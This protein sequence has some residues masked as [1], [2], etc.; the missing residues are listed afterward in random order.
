[1]EINGGI[2]LERKVKHSSKK[3]FDGSS[4]SK[5]YGKGYFMD[6]EGSNYGRKDE[7]G[8]LLF[9]PYDAE[10]YLY[11]DRLVVD[12]LLKSV[13]NIETAIVLGCARGYMVQAFHERNVEAVG[14]DI[15]EWAVENCAPM[16]ADHIYC[17]DVCDLSKWRD[18][19]FD[20]G[21]A[22]DVFEHIKVPDLYRAL[23]EAA[24]VGKMIVLD[25]P[26]AP[27]DSHPDQS[28]GTDK[29]HVSVYSKEFWVRQFMERGFE[30]DFSQE[31]QYPEAHEDSPWPDKHDHGAT[32]YFT[33]AKPKPGAPDFKSITIKPD[34]KNFKILWWS[35]S[36]FALTGYGIGTKGVV[37]PL[38][39]IYDVRCLSVYGLEGA[40]LYF[41]NLIIYPRLFDQFG[42]DAAQLIVKNW[43]PDVM[44]TLFDLWI[45]DSPLLEGQRDWF[46]KIHPKHIAYFPVDHEP[47]P[48]GVVNQAKQAYRAVTMSQFGQRAMEKAGVRNTMI[49]HGCLIYSTIVLTPEGPQELGQIVESK[50]KVKILAYDGNQYLFTDIQE[51]YKTSIKDGKIVRLV[52]GD[53]WLSGTQDHPILTDKGWVPLG[54]LRKGFNIACVYPRGDIY[55][56]GICSGNNRRRRNNLSFESNSKSKSEIS[57][58][59]NSLSTLL[60]D[61][62]LRRATDERTTPET[63]FRTS[64]FSQGR[65]Y[66]EPVH[67]RLSQRVQSKTNLGGY[68]A[69]PNCEEETS[70]TNASIH[71]QSYIEN[72]RKTLQG[73]I[74]SKGNRL[75]ESD[76]IIF[77][78]ASEVEVR[79]VASHERWVYDI[80][81]EYGNFIA[82]GIIV[83]NCD[84]NTFKPPEDKGKCRKWLYDHSLPLFANKEKEWPEK[85]F[86]L[87]A[88][89]MNKDQIKRKGWDKEFEAIRLF[90]D[91]N[92]DARKDFR[93]HLHT[94][95]QY[96]GGYPL[97][98]LVDK[99][100]FSDIT[101]KTHTYHMYQGLNTE[102]LATMYGGFDVLMNASRGEGFGIPIIEAASCGVPAI[103]T[104]FSSMTELIEGHGWLVNSITPDLTMLLSYMATPNEFQIADAIEDAYNNPD[105]VKQF[106]AASREFSLNY[107][108][109]NV[110]VPL[111]VQL[112]EE[113][114]EE[115]RPKSLDERRLI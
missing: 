115:M 12:V 10:S 9:S 106:G 16:V 85:C 81:T 48:E 92:P 27:D 33:K 39:K 52:A 67:A 89:A 8:K 59:G 112:F 44:V 56:L 77:E 68:I 96:P 80:K 54:N 17:G 65:I 94:W 40:A 24:R 41:N 105:K 74:L 75:G 3:Q 49:P 66:E 61:N 69:L 84:T 97:D 51:Y 111:W 46:T 101:R 55:G 86:V 63:Q 90:L 78:E 108:W 19:E 79:D 45:G 26:I 93:V 103:G 25:V 100:G 114:R 38:N 95:P 87:G 21:V 22:L 2:N 15:S 72:G 37:Y 107:D 6:A 36:P 58:T 11:R 5:F 104:R 20:V 82:N 88:N 35:N 43:K 4:P 60:N 83:H 31:Y 70:R 57:E 28:A 23:D 13:P 50:T 102:S 109:Q 18:G 64:D 29:T 34:S 30:P 1:M 98:H 91:D 47:A 76:K 14:V 113:I 7:E 53:K 99:M 110:I 73:E 62:K 32:I 71:Q 42:I